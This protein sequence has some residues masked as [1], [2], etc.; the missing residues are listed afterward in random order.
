MDFLFAQAA[1]CTSKR[2]GYQR[3]GLGMAPLSGMA[4]HRTCAAL[5]P[6]RPGCCSRTASTSTT[7]ADCASSE[8][9]FDPQWEPR[10]LASQGGMMPYIVMTDVAA[11]IAGSLKEVLLK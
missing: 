9:K 3:F 7:S 8:E 2:E 1:C 4:E 5:A 6:Q 11:M 10:Y